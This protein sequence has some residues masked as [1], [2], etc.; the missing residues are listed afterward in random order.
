[1]RGSGSTSTP[2]TRVRQGGSELA[3]SAA[4]LGSASVARWLA[5]ACMRHSKHGAFDG[6]S[7]SFCYFSCSRSYYITGAQ[8]ATMQGGVDRV[9]SNLDIM[10]LHISF[11][12][13]CSLVI[14]YSC[15][16]ASSLYVRCVQVQFQ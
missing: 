13:A 9:R 3:K 2:S 12:F 14:E 15:S 5:H 4:V 10:Y 1:M 11:Q 6:T 8:P 16:L 7:S